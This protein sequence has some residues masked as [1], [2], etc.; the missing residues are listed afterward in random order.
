MDE[1][2]DLINIIG[3]LIVAIIAC[4]VFKALVP[5]AV[6]LA[7]RFG[8]VDHPDS[9]KHHTQVT[10]L[11]GGLTV[12]SAFFIVAIIV[13]GGAVNWSMFAWFSFVLLVGVADDHYNLSQRLR[14]ILHALV[15]IGIAITDGHLV[16]SVGTIFGPATDLSFSFGVAVVFT[17]IAVVGAINAVNMIDGVDGLL[18]SLVFISLA[19]LLAISITS[20]GQAPLLSNIELVAF[21]GAIFGFLMM[22]SRF[23]GLSRARVFMG[24]AGSTTIGFVLVYLMIGSSQGDG[25]VISPVAA[26]WILGLPLLDASAVILMRV[27]SSKSP[28]EPGRDHLHHILLRRYGGVNQVIAIM[29]GCHASM[30]LVGVFGPG[31]IG[32]NADVLLF[33]LFVALVPVRCLLT[34]RIDPD[35]AVQQGLLSSK[36]AERFRKV[37][38]AD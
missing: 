14:I 29:A 22:N 23:L 15:V 35:M 38:Q 32:D 4:V 21:I 17:I 6:S 12:F 16:Y 20:D 27:L 25:A 2:M 34:L 3:Y 5:T 11:V 8:L 26:G 31:L 28:I 30:V 1:K 7:N 37:I 36:L 13:T 18:G 9:R 10:P 33:W 24:D 19:A